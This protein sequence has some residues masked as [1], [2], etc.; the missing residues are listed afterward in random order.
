MLKRALRDLM[1]ISVETVV[2]IALAAT[3]GLSRAELG[4]ESDIARA[5]GQRATREAL[6]IARDVELQSSS[7]WHR[8]IPWQSAGQARNTV[9]SDYPRV[10]GGRT[11]R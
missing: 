11:D 1:V 6:G 10:F 4:R 2:L 3:L 7:K 8:D 9:T 5:V